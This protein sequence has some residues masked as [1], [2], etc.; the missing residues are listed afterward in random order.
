MSE[1]QKYTAAVYLTIRRVEKL[2]L[3]IIY[4]LAEEDKAAQ[5]AHIKKNCIYLT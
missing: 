5:K 2:T 3:P 4:L 1:Y